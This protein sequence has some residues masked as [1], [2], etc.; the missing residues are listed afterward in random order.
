MNINWGMKNHL[1]RLLKY[2]CPELPS[3][4]MN[5]NLGGTGLEYVYFLKISTGNSDVFS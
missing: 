2:T 1:W 5:Q 3:Q 4:L